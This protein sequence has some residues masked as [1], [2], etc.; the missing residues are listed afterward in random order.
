V[1]LAEAAAQADA[2]ASEGKERE[3]AALRSE[4]ADDLEMAVRSADFR[5]RAVGYRAVAQFRFRAKTE[6]LRRGLED[7]SAA[8]RGAALVALAQLSKDSPGLVNGVRPLLHT[9]VS[10]DGQG[11]VRRLAAICLGHGSPQRDTITLLEGI[12]ANDEGERDLRET[13]KKVAQLLRK[14]ANTR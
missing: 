5:E 7:D 13:A 12:A 8:C 1:T 2:L 10:S 14:R 6:L 9:L 11:A 3:L 4:W